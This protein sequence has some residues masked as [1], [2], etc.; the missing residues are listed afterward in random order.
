[1]KEG[2][3]REGGEA[4]GEGS[5]GK[6]LRV[7]GEGEKLSWNRRKSRYRRRKVK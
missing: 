7:L 4:L 6:S 3:E 5:Q 2:G 1:M